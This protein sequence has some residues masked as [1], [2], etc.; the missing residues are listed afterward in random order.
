M[1]ASLEVDGIASN[2]MTIILSPVDREMPAIIAFAILAILTL[3]VHLIF[4]RENPGHQEGRRRHLSLTYLFIDARTKTYSL[5]QLQLILWTAA[6]IVAYAY[7]AASQALVQWQWKLC[8]IPENLPMLLGIS[9]GTTVMS[10]GA[11][12]ILGSK[13]AGSLHPEWG[14]FISS[15]G[16]FAPERLQ[17]FL[18][19]VIGVFGFVSATLA[20]DPASV[21]DL[22]RIPDSFIPLMGLSSM[23]YLAGKVTRK[24]GPIIIR[25]DPPPDS[26]DGGPCHIFGENLS[27]RAQVIINGEPL[28][29]QA[30]AVGPTAAADSDFVTELIVIPTTRPAAAGG[31]AGV[32]VV[33]P[34]GQCA[35]I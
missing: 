22:P 15:G 7:I 17:F 32:K 6:A 33:N 20:Q 23:G 19:T 13:G 4:R 10:L 21:T 16:V 28:P 14:D 12:T 27:R 9:V 18:W 31:I 25:V 34:D 24:P 30:I 5:S 1:S 2:R 35:N 29:A 3:L 26:V 8:E 11:T